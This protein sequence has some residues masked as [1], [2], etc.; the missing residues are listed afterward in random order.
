MNLP[1]IKLFG[2]TSAT[3]DML[4]D[5][6]AG[7]LLKSLLHYA[8][9]QVDDLPG[10][11]KLVF[12][13]LKTQMDRDAASYQEYLDKQ[14]EN[15]KK[16]GRPKNPSLSD[17]NPENPSLFLK[18]QKSQDKDKDK[19]KDKE[20]DKDKDKDKEEDKEED[21]NNDYSAWLT[22][23]DIMEALER[24]R[25]IEETARRWGLPYTEGHMLKARDLAST[26]TLE[27]LLKAIERSGDGQRQ[28]WGYVEGILRNWMQ[29]GGIDTAKK[30]EKPMRTTGA[31]QYTQRDYAEDDLDSV[32]N[33]LIAEAKRLRGA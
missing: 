4:S 32:T 7:R 10:Q 17:E 3:V 12:A 28:T 18:T 24:D 25:Q 22:D 33:D 8:S 27:W 31:T 20:E 11:E 9:G 19:D 29:K 6:E 13:M 1:Y 16:G 21:N 15:G 26:Y 23:D 30:P 2:D 14:R 5:A